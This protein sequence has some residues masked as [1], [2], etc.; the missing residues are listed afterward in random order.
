[1]DHLHALLFNERTPVA[2]VL[3][4]PIDDSMPSST[5]HGEAVNAYLKTYRVDWVDWEDRAQAS[6][7]YGAKG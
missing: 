2:R 4:V 3:R 7:A 5:S 6:S 1:M